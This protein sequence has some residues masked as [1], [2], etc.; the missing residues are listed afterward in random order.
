MQDFIDKSGM[1]E[2]GTNPATV[3]GYMGYPEAAL[4]VR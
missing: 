2:C 4:S 3:S 1:Q